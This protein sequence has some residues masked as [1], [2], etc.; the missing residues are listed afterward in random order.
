VDENRGKRREKGEGEARTGRD[1]I[2]FWKLLILVIVAV[3]LVVKHSVR[4]N[5]RMFR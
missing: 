1:G 5:Q 2:F 4:I 3:T